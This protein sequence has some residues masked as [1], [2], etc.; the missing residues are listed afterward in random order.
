MKMTNLIISLM[1]TLSIIGI[2]TEDITTNKPALQLAGFGEALDQLKT[3]LDRL[4]TSLDRLK[5]SLERTEQFITKIYETV[6]AITSF[7]GLKTIIVLI[8]TFGIASGIGTTGIAKGKNIFILSLLIVDLLWFFWFGVFYDEKKE[9]LRDM[10]KSNLL[11][12]SPFLLIILLK[13]IMPPIY[14]FTRSFNRKNVHTKKF[15]I[16][17]WNEFNTESSNFITNYNNDI[18]EAN[19]SVVLSADTTRSIKKLMIL[20]KELGS[21][22]KSV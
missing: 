9:L 21:K 15:C 3:S 6:K 5:T 11:I 17:H 10:I 8:I 7:A 22:E 13:Y 18:H 1:L 16:K 12:L 2:F 20:L 14:R 4:K 19:N